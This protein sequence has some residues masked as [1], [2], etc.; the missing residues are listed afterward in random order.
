MPLD[1]LLSALTALLR[2]LGPEVTTDPLGTDATLLAPVL[3]TAPG[4]R[5]LP[6]LA[7]SMLGPA[8]LYSALVRVLGRLSER[9]PLIA[10]IDDAHLAGP[11]LR[12]WVR[13]VRREEITLA[14][15]AAIRAGEGEPL[16]ATAFIHLGVLG[17][18]AAAELVGQAR[19]EELLAGEDWT[20]RFR[21]EL[22]RD[23][24]A[25]SATAGRAALLHRTAGRMLA[26]R[27]D[28]DPATVA[29]HARLG[30]DLMLASRALREA[31]ARAAERFDHAAAEA[32]LDDALHLHP[33]PGGWLARARV[34]TRRRRYREAL[35]DV[36]LAVAAGPAALEV[37][38]W[39]SYFGRR[40]TQAAHTRCPATRHKRWPP[41]PATPLRR[42][43]ARS[44]ASP[45]G[46]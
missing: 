24:L 5:P 21:H 42:T 43:G 15:V 29:H 23:A 28:A 33:D 27:P 36:E 9:G 8:V 11:A 40:F 14:V 19:V 30:G 7:D 12:D 25:A 22:V 2:R 4:P 1:A 35:Q 13:F 45:A 18:E 20:F 46:R 6:M 17:R 37:G 39:A 26:Q 10:V 32:L 31:A 44:R 38:A 3:G 34:R 16:P 41:S